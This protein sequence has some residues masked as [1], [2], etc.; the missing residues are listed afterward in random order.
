MRLVDYIKKDYKISFNKDYADALL[1]ENTCPRTYGETLINE[2][3][4]VDRN[5]IL[6]IDTNT[7]KIT[8]EYIDYKERSVELNSKEGIEIL[9]RWYLKYVNLIRDLYKNGENIQPS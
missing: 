3:I 9:D 1:S 8:D 4:C 6:T 2:I 7:K 5:K